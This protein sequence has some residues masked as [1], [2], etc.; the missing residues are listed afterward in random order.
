MR[1]RAGKGSAKGDVVAVGVVGGIDE[2][3]AHAQQPLVLRDGASRG[4]GVEDASEAGEVV[5]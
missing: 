2:G 1:Q 4:G 3:V 5:S